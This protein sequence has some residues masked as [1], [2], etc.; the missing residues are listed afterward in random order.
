[1]SSQRFTE[2][3]TARHGTAILLVAC[4]LVL[5]ACASGPKPA[6]T[7]ATDAQGVVREVPPKA[8]TLYEQAV[9]ALA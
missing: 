9:S 2:Q 7:G 1:M 3:R 8:Q 5:S 6:K 4:G